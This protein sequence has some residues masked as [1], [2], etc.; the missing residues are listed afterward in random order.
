M[1]RVNE[2]DFPAIVDIFNREGRTAFNDY[3]QNTYGLKNPRALLYRIRKTPGYNYDEST[4]RFETP[5]KAKDDSIFMSVEELCRNSSGTD[6]YDKR[7]AHYEEKPTM[8]KLIHELISD[9]LLE[10]RKYVILE[11]SSK[12]IIIDKTSMISDGYQVLTH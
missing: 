2:K 5:E 10:L 12:T 6:N 11:P 4:H 8:D 1:K 9:R 3:I 7:D